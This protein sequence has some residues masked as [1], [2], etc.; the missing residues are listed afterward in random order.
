MRR[1][2]LLLPLLLT[3]CDGDD[4]APPG[5]AG[6]GGYVFPPRPATQVCRFDGHAPGALPAVVGVPAFE[7]LRFER[8]VQVFA[9]PDGRLAV[10]ERA[11]RIVV[12]GD[13]VEVVADVRASV[14]CCDD[15][16]G[17]LSAAVHAASGRLF[18]VFATGPD[19]G[20]V[21]EVGPGG[22]V[23]RLLDVP[24]DGGGH[25]LLGPDERLY[26]TVGDRAG[27]GRPGPD[28]L[29]G[30]VLRIGLDGG[31]RVWAAGLRD[32]WRCAFG[33]SDAL[34]CGDAGPD[35]LD[36]IDV[37]LEN[38][39]HG[40]PAML[41]RACRTE[42]CQPERYAGPLH[43]FTRPETAC[44]VVGGVHYRGRGAPSLAGAYLFADRCDGA[45][46]ALRTTRVGVS[47][48][49]RVGR[50]DHPVV[51]LGEDGAGTLY[52]VDE[53]GGRL[54]RL[55]VPPPEPGFPVRLS[56]SGCF[57]DLPSLT[58]APGVLRYDVNAPLWTDGVI[59]DRHLVVPPDAAIERTGDG[60][61]R[62][63]AGSVLLKT[64]STAERP[65]ETRVMVRRALDWAFHTYRWN[66]AGTDADL[67]SERVTVEV[68]V[69]TD[70]GPRPVSYLFPDRAGCGVC[71]GAS[72]RVLGPGDPQLDRGDQ[73]Q[74]MDDIQLFTEPGH[75]A[76]GPSMPDVT[77]ETLPLE[78]RA[79]AYLHAN[80]AH[81]HRPGGW[82]P[83]GLGLDLRAGT[84]L[85]D[86]GLCGV[87]LRYASLWAGGAW[88][89]APG[90]PS[91]S[92]LLQRMRLRGNGQMPPIGTAR[93]DPMGL[94]L[95]EAWIESIETC[96]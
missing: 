67:Q 53:A 92:N 33:P 76:A 96:P 5:D 10:V 60:G 95:V 69:E 32:P 55:E 90:V 75:A 85:G 38:S 82:Q 16:A 78:I 72:G 9:W 7:G 56:E 18:A 14:A 29:T 62:F 27:R 43:R 80:C 17:L 94:A 41:G 81:C 28:A 13:E 84:P 47:E 70:E 64:F 1:A 65:I 88:R 3:A 73:L 12:A 30:A 19:E 52:A 34:W 57:E 63:P 59:K 8:P 48:V 54:T 26:L 74:A 66:D 11:G 37:V 87:P 31:H 4:P 77:D 49:A 20:V 50:L 79:R 86:A 61:W 21:A 23:R 22:V 36:E 46:R 2:L 45:V 58:A 24:L 6:P 15:A 68:E 93:P 91:E 42:A 35:G 51:H 89:V 39:D 71:H 25:L 83:P 40:W 44:G